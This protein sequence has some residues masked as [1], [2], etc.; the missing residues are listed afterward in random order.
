MLSRVEAT[1]G[2]KETLT[3]SD[4]LLSLVQKEKR[5][6]EKKCRGLRK[7]GTPDEAEEAYLSALCDL[8]KE[9]E[10]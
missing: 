9:L 10:V 3:Q 2:Q 7:G 1:F 6:T 4:A 8:I 5:A